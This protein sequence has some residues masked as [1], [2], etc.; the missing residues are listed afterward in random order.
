M[1]I[2]VLNQVY[3]EARRLA[4]AGSVVAQGDFRLKKLVGP[5]EQA[6]AKAPVFAKVAEAANKV[7][8]GPEDASAANL[9][10]LTALVTA[11]LYTQG[12][13][14]LPGDLKPIETINLGGELA[15]TSARLLKPLLE[16]LKS[17]GSGRLELVKEAHERGAFRDLRLIKPALGGLDDPYPELADFISEKVLPLYGKAILPELRRTYDQ[18][19]TKGHPRRL[20]LMHALD[21]AG[22]RDLVKQALEGGSKE[23]KVAAISCLGAE[24]EDLQFLVEQA[25]AK[26]Q[27]VRG[28]AYE[29]LAG[30]DDPAA[31]A[32][33]QKAI[34]GKDLNLAI[35]SISAS[36]Q[37]RP[38]RLTALLVA[39]VRKGADELL[40]QKDKKKVSD[41]ADRLT[42]LIRA[43]PDEENPDANRITLDLFA[44]RAELAKIKGTTYSGSDVVEAVLDHME[45]GPKSLRQTLARAHGELDPD[46]THYA[47][48]AGRTSLPA[49]ELYDVFAPYVTAKLDEKKKGKDPAKV[50]RDA[51][52]DVIGDPYISWYWDEEQDEDAGPPLDP[53]WLD[54]ALKLRNLGLVYA[55]RRPGHKGV[56]KFLQEEFDAQFKKV[57]QQDA[58]DDLLT[59]MVHLKHPKAADNLLASYEKTIGKANQYTY[60]FHR[61]IP[62]L[63]KDA[64]PK[65]E[66]VVPRL[67]GPE[68]DQFVEA[69][70]E[71]RTKKD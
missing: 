50:R 10:E 31:V 45:E 39:E 69:I 17:T 52:L 2:A 62:Q 37:A 23:I 33:L 4:V 68:A 12:E 55:V 21:P 71:L 46:Q 27:D 43:L 44:R 54:L 53:R 19:G 36:G 18:P 41:L 70:Q 8:D 35:C 30:I 38:A 16:A 49:A 22:T 29:A 59:V 25:A 1:S 60:W 40:K 24:P 32:V 66:A 6:G 57:K 20:K 58:L 48:R 5:L 14:G 51:V 64:L 61:L 7:I 65:L 56:E 15:Q 63:P 47:V 13:T 11:V 28:A 9:L 3:D 67:K 34:S 26:A 42:D